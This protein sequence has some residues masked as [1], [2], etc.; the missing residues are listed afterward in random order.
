LVF[1]VTGQLTPAEMLNTFLPSQDN[2]TY[3]KNGLIPNL[4]ISHRGEKVQ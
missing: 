2:V 3:N 1:N 4:R